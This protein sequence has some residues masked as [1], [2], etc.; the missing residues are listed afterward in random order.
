LE[1][2]CG[3][4]NQLAL[5]NYPN[6][7]G[8]DISE[9]VINKCKKNFSKEKN[10][11]FYTLIDFETI[12]EENVFDLSLSLDVIYHLVEDK[13]FDLHMKTL[14][15][16]SQYVI[17]FST[18]FSDYFYPKQHVKNRKFTDWI[19]KNIS[20]YELIEKIRNENRFSKVDFYVYKKIY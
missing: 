15:Y 13:V 16:S 14:F 3:D 1:L 9:T 4:G 6:Y 7:V 20:N 12:K 19:H 8:I 17:I 11:A 10:K 2:G 18:N 5:A